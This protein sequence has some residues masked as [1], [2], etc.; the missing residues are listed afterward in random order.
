MSKKFSF[1]SFLMLTAILLSAF[2]VLPPS[3][4]AASER[5]VMAPLSPAFLEWQAGL[6]SGK[7]K[8]NL[9]KSSPNSRNNGYIPFP[10]DLSYLADNPPREISRYDKASS[11][12]AK[13]DLRDVEGK[14]YVSS[15]RNQGDY[16]TCWAFATTGA[17]E[18][19]YLKQKGAGSGIDLSEMHLAYFALKN[20]DKSKAFDDYSNYY[21]P[22]YSE[23]DNILM[24]GG[25]NN[26]T[27]AIYG[28]LDGPILESELPYSPYS[29]VTPSKT[30]PE[31]YNRVLR[32]RD[33]YVLSMPR[34]EINAS[35]E[36]RN[37]I[38]RI[39]M[40]NGSVA[41]SYYH[42]NAG[43][44]EDNKSYYYPA[45]S[46]N[47][48]VQIIGWDDTYPK[49]NFNYNLSSN[50]AWLIKNSWGDTWS[51]KDSCFWL[52]YEQFLA[53][54]SAF[55]VEDADKDMKAYYY[56]ALGWIGY[57]YY[58]NI[59]TVYSANIFQSERDDENLTEV[60]FY[61]PDNN[62]S[63][64]VNIY[65]GM[66]STALS[67]P[68]KG[69]SLSTK[70]GTEAY[71]G[72]HTVTLSKPVE[73][74]KGE[75]FSVVIKL[76]GTNK[77][78]L[79]SVLTGFSD[80]V[81]FEAGSFFSSN[82]SYWT[83]ASNNSYNTCVRAFT[84]P[85][86]T[87]PA[88][89]I[90]SLP[91][92]A[93]N[94]SYNH[95]FSA[96]GSSPITWSY[97]GSLPDGL[98]L[99]EAGILSGTPTTKGKYTF[100][101]TATN[102]YGN[103]SRAFTLTIIDKPVI[104]TNYID[105][106]VG[107]SVNKTLELEDGVTA[108]QW[109]IN[110]GTIPSGLKF[111]TTIG[112]ITGTPKTAGRYTLGLSAGTQG[113]WSEIKAFDIF[114]QTLTKPTISL[115]NKEPAVVGQEYTS[116]LNLEGTF[117]I[118]LGAEI[119]GMPDG[120]KLENQEQELVITGTPTKAENYT[121]K[122]K[123]NNPYTELKN[124]NVPVEI[125]VSLK[126]IDQAPVIKEPS[127][128]V[129]ILNEDY[130]EYQ[131]ETSAGTGEIK[132][133]ASGLPT[134]LK[135]STDGK[136]T[137]TPTKAGPFTATIYAENFGNKVHIEIP[138]TVYQLP[139]ITT[140]SLPDATD[141]KAYTATLKATGTTPITWSIDEDLPDGLE[142]NETTGT[143]SGTPTKPGI[144][145][146]NF[147][148]KNESKFEDT[149]ELTLKVNAVPPAIT[150]TAILPMQA[151]EYAE[152][153]I[154]ATGSMP[155]TFTYS[156]N[157]LFKD[158]GLDFEYEEDKGTA[159]IKGTPK[160]A[161]TFPIMITASNAQNYGDYSKNTV[162]KILNLT[163]KAT[164]PKI[165]TPDYDG[166]DKN[167]FVAVAGQPYGKEYQFKLSK[168]TPPITWTASG[169]PAGMKL[170]ADGKLEGTPTKAG[171]FKATITAKNSGGQYQLKEVPFTVYE[172]PVITTKS[173][174]AATVGVEY[175]AALTATGSPTEWG[176]TGDLPK[177]LEIDKNTGK[178]SG[179]PA[180]GTY[181]TYELIIAAKNSAGTGNPVTLTL[182]VKVIP[183]KITTTTIDN[184]EY[185]PDL[186]KQQDYEAVIE[187]T[188]SKPIFF[189]CTLDGPDILTKNNSHLGFT[190]EADEENGKLTI[191]GK[192]TSAGSYK[193][194][195]TAYNDKNNR[196]AN[197]VKKE[198]TLKITGVAPELK[199]I[200]FEAD[201]S[202]AVKDTEYEYQFE[203]EKGTTP[204]KWT[205][206]GLPAGLTLEK[207][208]TGK[209]VKLSG[210]P[211]KAGSFKV[212]IN[213]QNDD[214]KTSKTAAL[215]VYEKPKITTKSLPA[216][217]DGKA[218]NAA[219]TATGTKN[220]TW[221]FEIIGNDDNDLD[222]GVNDATEVELIDGLGLKLDKKTGKISGT[223][224]GFGI[225]NINFTAANKAGNSEAKNLTLT[226]NPVAPAITTAKL[227]P[228]QADL[229]DDAPTYT[230]EISANGSKPITFTCEVNDKT[231]RTLA[232]IGL[233]LKQTEAQ[234]NEGKA[235][236]TGK[237]TKWGT[238]QLKITATNGED[239]AQKSVM[240]P[241]SLKI[242]ALAPKIKTPE[243]EENENSFV[244][245]ANKNF[246]GYDFEVS[247]GTQPVTW[248]ASGLPAGLKI[249]KDS[250]K[251][252]GKPTKA[253]SF[254]ATVTAQ[255]GGGKDS[256]KVNFTVYE[257]PTITA[258]KGKKLPDATTDKKYTATL[259]AKGTTPINWEIKGLA[260]ENDDDYD[261]LKAEKKSNGTQLVISGT[262]TKDKTYNLKIKATNKHSDENT[263]EQE[264]TLTVN[265]VPVKLTASL[266]AG[267]VGKEYKGS[268]ISASGTKPIYFELDDTSKALFNNENEYGLKFDFDKD[269]G[270]AE[271]TGTPKKV[272]NQQITITAW[273]KD[274]K[275]DKV[276]LKPLALK[277]NAYPVK[278]TAALPAGKAGTQYNAK[279]TATGSLPI[280]W[281]YSVGDNEYGIT[282]DNFKEKLGLEFKANEDDSSKAAIEG[283]PAKI[284]KNLPITIT[285]D[286]EFGNAV[287]RKLNLTING[288][289]PRL[290]ANLKPGNAG[291]AYSEK[292][293]ATGDG[294]TWD[295]SV[296]ANTYEITKEN[297]TE[298]LGLKFTPDAE[299]TS[300]T[301][302]LATDTENGGVL[303]KIVTNLPITIT[304]TNKF[305]G[306]T[307]KALK[308]T[309]KG[310]N[311]TLKTELPAG[312]VG[313]DY[314]A[315]FTASGKT[316][317]VKSITIDDNAAE[318]LTEV[319]LT[320]NKFEAGDDNEFFNEASAKIS[321][322]PKSELTNLSIKVT[323]ENK[324]GGKVE[325]TLKLNIKATPA[326]FK[327]ASLPAADIG[328]DYE[329]KIQVTG[330]LPLTTFT[331]E[332]LNL[333]DEQVNALGLK[334]EADENTGIAEITGEPKVAG[335]YTIRITASNGY[336]KAVTKNFILAVNNSA[337]KITTS[338]LPQ[339]AYNENYS[340][341]IETSGAL[342]FTKFECSIANGKLDDYGLKFEAD[343]N[344]GTAEITGKPTQSIKSLPITINVNDGKAKKTFNLVIKGGKP[345]FANENSFT[346]AKG[347]NVEIPIVL[348][349][350]PKF[351]VTMN[352]VAGFNIKETEELNKFTI[353]GTA[354]AS[355][356]KTI[357]FKVTAK[358]SEGSAVQNITLKTVEEEPAVD[359]G[360]VKPKET[361]SQPEE[362]ESVNDETSQETQELETENETQTEAETQEPGVVNFGAERSIES[363]G[364]KEFDELEGYIVAAV[365][366]EISV[367]ESDMYDFEIDIAPEIE[368][369]KELTWFAFAKNR[370]KN[371]D[372]EIAEF[373]K[374]DGSETNK[375]TADHK[376]I[377]SVWLNV[378]DIYEPVIAVKTSDDAA[379]SDDVQVPDEAENVSE[380]E[381]K[382][383]L[384][385]FS[386][387][388]K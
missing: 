8:L 125:P 278:L 77:I 24:H 275:S 314:E 354:P 289:L 31:S 195:V 257:L 238:F 291:A 128:P 245:E 115:E 155:I 307:E 50:G 208:Q 111:N 211:T 348:K 259:T 384:E 266:A 72:Y 374:V 205:A 136:L 5:P 75:Y 203:L 328:R 120:L 139:V 325:K 251:L 173:L 235:T 54:G 363:L 361:Q 130:A 319:G 249:D 41:A 13:Y 311:P 273:H 351:T 73:L 164:P 188:G 284:V 169:L 338:S 305:G 179:T 123:A 269:K 232:D 175:N 342:P 117:P 242:N 329:Q 220:I 359:A 357:T 146:F 70:T 280:T 154:T 350:S 153:K 61:T 247:K 47:H 159:T 86:N 148:A 293:T 142:F 166:E 38:K 340:A 233:E 367:T 379:I 194:V 141:G 160:V 256:E 122:F 14:R 19:N 67:T 133:T 119:I 339:A 17:M 30:T 95:Q 358:N 45:Y 200:N 373:F 15:V 199:G 224:T 346:K 381:E 378:G 321:G 3:A 162:S 270:T 382:E 168:G 213:A 167:K 309:V 255:N 306:K 178:I 137:G 98:S 209:T 212:T 52:S 190:A 1:M 234:Q 332:W 228:A 121:V 140:T 198:Y 241:L 91:A 9:D 74:T 144:Y 6:K 227:N 271:I 11:I 215:T 387:E 25:N 65:K 370:A 252:S 327:T 161:G 104:K 187:T 158:L 360:N 85:S 145:A 53:D 110:Y 334:L 219:L 152:R 34:N 362:S 302:T 180:G 138:F 172:V 239:G 250:G 156:S 364:S 335:K 165:E 368:A 331:A 82:G 315:K 26:M 44:N 355:A 174:P 320:F 254:T 316:L 171:K 143:I 33:V 206:A 197:E 298:K 349:G 246:A 231:Y 313:R 92:G 114:V 181:G 193:L 40:Q 277:I 189:T 127:L 182:E 304:A 345:E 99:S 274:D 55:I 229:D 386:K 318:K 56:D 214:G 68:V 88:I 36:S 157:N 295:Y 23:L 371:T 83:N 64:E 131:F 258:L 60:A 107:Y 222:S 380:Q 312:D 344:K 272:I 352:K 292:F 323:A 279:F 286:N 124:N 176:L 7:S 347:S 84:V 204:I 263:E 324:Y 87:A 366:P 268:K 192:P 225:L 43:Y 63:Y 170:T 149:K 301:A 59:S 369:G 4:Q 300:S 28:R 118:N 253:G 276:S 260:E 94:V 51:D 377:V 333:T 326:T 243:F 210:T 42:D 80:N 58:N 46:T 282:K 385:F 248:T 297:L 97:S 237:P 105:A 21:D 112:A 310:E 230:A 151:D 48:A 66:T 308:L 221:D 202:F 183:P 356:G 101:V 129:A 39:I 22:R 27:T 29:A 191:K 113:I 108:D 150:T 96:S 240:K 303:K 100:T 196:T 103:N 102:E 288:D 10:V 78:P 383:E 32:L 365:L 265:A 244:I 18:S 62:V 2:S 109:K 281:D 37:I 226:V 20:P 81:T 126:V 353:T 299:E 177:G 317:P 236:I 388:P 76:T 201:D 290:T 134:G 57:I 262:P 296:G 135:L 341:E 116:V 372:D 261:G 343:V 79:E 90:N 186:E 12:P 163:I 132:W 375:T 207:D 147:T 71:A 217:M 336:G 69:A 294:I 322:K 287:E 93:V 185:D 16:G 264:F 223:P 49:E 330:T 283:T 216:A 89:T 337:P 106:Y 267:E 285:A 218:Y 35:D 376:I 184:A